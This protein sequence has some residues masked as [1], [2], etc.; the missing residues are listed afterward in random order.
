[1]SQALS[2][3]YSYYK[4]E[5]PAELPRISS[6]VTGIHFSV[7]QNNWP[8]AQELANQLQQEFAKLKASIEDNQTHIFQMLELSLNDLCTAVHNQDSVLVLIRTNLVNSNIR[9]LDVRLSQKQE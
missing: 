2:D 8:K 6:G 7:K 9:E 4:T 1:M 5:I 3:F